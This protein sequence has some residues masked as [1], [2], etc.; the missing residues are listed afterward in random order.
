VLKALL[1]VPLLLLPAL[2][3]V[4]ALRRPAA[5]GVKIGE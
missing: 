4:P 1:V 3:L 2:A 5:G